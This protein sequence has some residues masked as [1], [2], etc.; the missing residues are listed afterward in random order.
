MELFPPKQRTIFGVA[1]EFFWAIGGAMVPLFA[2]YIR[3]WRTLQLLV[4][5]P[6]ILGIGLWWWVIRRRWPTVESCAGPHLRLW[7]HGQDIFKGDVSCQTHFSGGVGEG[8]GAV[9][10]GGGG[11]GD[12][13]GG[14]GGGGG[15]GAEGWGGVGWGGGGGGGGIRSSIWRGP[16]LVGGPWACAQAALP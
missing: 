8:G 5:V 14:G 13:D 11:E 15:G 16:L 6:G 4:S 7:A 3:Y 9:G 12:G 2:Y 1:H 10:G